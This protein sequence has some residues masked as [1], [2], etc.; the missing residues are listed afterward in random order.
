MSLK[1]TCTT[2][3]KHNTPEAVLAYLN[4]L[5]MEMKFHVA[6]NNFAK[7]HPLF[8]SFATAKASAY[9]ALR[10]VT[11]AEARDLFEIMRETYEELPDSKAQIEWIERK[12]DSFSIPPMVTKG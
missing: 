6:N 7:F 5:V 12:K 8:A 10:T 2:L 1:L 4:Y 11:E 3:N 9:G